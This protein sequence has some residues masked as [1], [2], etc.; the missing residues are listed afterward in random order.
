MFLIG[1]VII[2]LVYAGLQALTDKPK[3]EEGRLASLV[4]STLISGFV[5]RAALLQL[6][7]LDSDLFF[8]TSEDLK[9]FLRWLASQPVTFAF[10]ALILASYVWKIIEKKKGGSLIRLPHGSAIAIAIPPRGKQNNAPGT[11][12]IA[13]AYAV[14]STTFTRT[15]TDAEGREYPDRRKPSWVEGSEGEYDEPPCD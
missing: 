14:S 12:T 11:T 3:V 6:G 5:M 7:V 9:T 1:M 13:R 8:V 15:Y 10:L 2:A 4:H